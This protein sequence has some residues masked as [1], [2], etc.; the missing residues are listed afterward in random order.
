MKKWIK[1]LLVT[2]GII[3]VLVVTTILLLPP[4]AKNYLEK[5]S[6]ELV[7]RQI[8]IEKLRFNVLNGK[9]RIDQIAM[10]EPDDSTTFASLGNFYTRIHL[11]PLLRQ[12]IHIDAVLIDKPYLNVYQD[13]TSFNFDDLLT[14]FLTPADTVEKAP[15]NPWTVDIDDIKIHNGELTY[16]DMQRNVTWGFNELDI[17]VPGL[18]LSG[19]E[20]TDMGIVFNFSRGGSLRTSLE[21][22][23]ATAD[24][25]LSLLLSNLS[26]AGTAAYFN[27]VI[28]IGSVEGLVTLDLHVKGNAN[29]LLDLRT[30]G[31]AAASGLKLRDSRDN[32][33]IDVDTLNFDLRDGN[34]GTMQ[35]DIRRIYAAGIR[36][37]FEIYRG[38]GNNLLA[39]I[40]A[41]EERPTET[42]A[43][44]DGETTV[45]IEREEPA[46]TQLNFT[47]GELLLDKGEIAFTDNTFEKPFRYLIS[48]IRLSSRDIDFSKQN[49]LTLDAKLQRTGSGHIRWKGS[50]QNLDN[51]NLMVA[52]SNI[53]LKDFTPYCEHFTAY[54]LT[55]GNLTFRSQNI[56]ADRFLNGTNH[57]DIFQ[58]EVD[59]KRKDL[60]PEF[61]IPLKLG[62]YI[63]KDRKGHVK[64]DLDN[65]NLMVAL[66]NINLKDFTPYCEHFTAYPLTGGN[67]TF[68]SQNIIADRF[69]NGTN[70]L[71]IFQCE[72]DKKRKDLEPEFK[73]PLKLGLYILKDRKGH[74]KID[75]PVKGNLDSPEFSYRKIVMKALGNVLLKVVTAPFSFLTGGGDNLDRIEV[76]PLQFSLN[77]DQYA[78]LDK[79][80]DILRDKPEMQIGLAQR[81]NRSK[82]VGRLAELN[83][84]M[85]CYNS[86]LPAGERLSMIDFERIQET[87]LKS[88]EVMRFADSL[89]A[90]R[91]IDGSKLSGSRKALTLYGDQAVGQL[92]KILVRRDSA[93]VEY[94]TRSQGIPVTAIS[95]RTIPAQELGDYT[96]KDIYA[97]QLGMEE[98]SIDVTDGNT[99]GDTE[100]T[101]TSASATAEVLATVPEQAAVQLTQTGTAKETA[102][103]E[104]SAPTAT[105]TQSTQAETTITESEAGITTIKTPT[106]HPE[107]LQ[108]NE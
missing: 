56:I 39:L 7:G 73:I 68:R 48:D 62:L 84:K 6:K 72:V 25:D 19:H 71:D 102:T 15:S 99:A 9:L 87:K 18:H 64:I 21:Y 96:G 76:D 10:L 40:K 12:R 88:D 2:L 86:T 37:Q 92:E 54:P 4:I 57:L 49:E 53:N 83:L 105:A 70:H 20:R 33:I 77:T 106:A 8:T 81:I 44:I 36:T 89:L 17:D 27:Q 14:R 5:H 41:P 69:L 59:K 24:Y 58:C 98:E 90:L 1:I 13:G 22:D 46:T 45:T 55:G 82:A 42:E 28:D 23:Q 91:G 43:T 103:P 52:L 108:T 61:K 50:L 101:D 93:I 63:L 65:H 85:A 26:L 94:L 95:V 47:V 16:K 35:Y 32:R 100:T 107:E 66:S 11:L 31:I 38:G 75:L 79:V 30:Y 60:E 34:L 78:T 51:H 3:A 74:V 80:A 67:L 29:H 104:P 97:I